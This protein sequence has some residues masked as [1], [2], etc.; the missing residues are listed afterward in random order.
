MTPMYAIALIGNPPI[1][2][3]C[4][5]ETPVRSI[6]CSQSVSHRVAKIS[7]LLFLDGRF[8]CFVCWF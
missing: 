4:D 7:P 8:T 5:F 6:V 3:H 2:D 1:P